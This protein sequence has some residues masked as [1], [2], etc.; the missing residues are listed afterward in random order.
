MKSREWVCNAMKVKVIHADP[1]SLDRVARYAKR[2][3]AS[4]LESYS[5]W[6]RSIA[7]HVDFGSDMFLGEYDYHC[8]AQMVTTKGHKMT[9]EVRDCD[10]ILAVY[11]AFDK[12]TYLMEHQLRDQSGEDSDHPK[13]TLP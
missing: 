11:R 3:V 13:Y 12:V 6:I 8:T 10:E 1:D 4:T 5:Q 7:V 2:L 9:A